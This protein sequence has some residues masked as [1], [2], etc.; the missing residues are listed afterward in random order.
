MNRTWTFTDLEL[1]AFWER[2]TTTWLPWPLIMTARVRTRSEL[3]SQIRQALNRVERAHPEFVDT[4]LKTLLEPDIQIAVHGSDGSDNTK[5][6]TLVRVYAVRRGDI[7]YVVTQKPGETYWHSGGYTVTECDALRLADVVVQAIP[8]APA[9]READY[10]LPAEDRAEELDYSYASSIVQDSFTD[11]VHS[12]S[13][14]FMAARDEYVG[15]IDITQGRSRFGPRGVTR[16]RLEWRDIEDDGRYVI[17]EGTPAT[18]VAAD[19][20]RLVQLINGRIAEVVRAIKD[21]RA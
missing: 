18:A 10:I 21:E 8:E 7:G 15:T 11:S 3:D 13:A 1:F 2:A 9:G 12:R 17:T 19:G 16:H 14:R 20:K 6:D 4:V 5:P